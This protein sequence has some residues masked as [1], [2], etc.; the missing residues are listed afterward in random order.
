MFAIRQIRYFIRRVEVKNRMLLKY[1]KFFYKEIKF[2]QKK[3]SIFFKYY[4]YKG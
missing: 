3:I 1:G 2:I 4:V